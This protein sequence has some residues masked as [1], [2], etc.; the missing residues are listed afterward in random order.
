MIFERWG[1]RFAIDENFM[2]KVREEGKKVVIKIN[3]PTFTILRNN[4]YATVP[5]EA[6]INSRIR[7]SLVQK[8]EVKNLFFLSF[9]RLILKR[10]MGV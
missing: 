7:G 5:F 8:L 4:N 1:G 3:F 6:I 10:G 2:T 9:F